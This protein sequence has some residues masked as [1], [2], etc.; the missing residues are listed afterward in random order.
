MTKKS[1]SRRNKDAAAAMA[2]AQAAGRPVAPKP[3]QTYVPPVAAIHPMF[4]KKLQEVAVDEAERQ[5]AEGW[6]PVWD[7]LNAQYVACAKGVMAPAV[8][9]VYAQRRD[10]I[11]YIRDQKGLQDRIGM[12]KRDILQLKAELSAIAREHGDKTGGTSDPDELM[13]AIQISEKY[14]L[15]R[16]RL[17]AIVEPTVLHIQEIFLEGEMLML[18]AQ[19]KLSDKGMSPEQD[20]DVITDVEITETTTHAAAAVAEIN[21]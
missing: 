21:A 8:L 1:M 5:K 16:E 15:F 10:I 4:A 7:E 20:P 11:A 14:N 18:Q 2:A 12:F 9:S 6:M 19:G 17:T 3:R 13:T